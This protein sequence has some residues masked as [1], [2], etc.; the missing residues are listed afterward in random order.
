[1][2]AA[3]ATG[4]KKMKLRILGANVQQQK[5]ELTTNDEIEVLWFSFVISA[6]VWLCS[7]TFYTFF[8]LINQ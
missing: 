8:P 1:M 4:V 7:F 5:N 2:S 6:R 3:A